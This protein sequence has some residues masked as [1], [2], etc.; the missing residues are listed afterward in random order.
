MERWRNDVQHRLSQREGRERLFESYS[1][2]VCS[3]L[4]SY[5]MDGRAGAPA[6]SNEYFRTEA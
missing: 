1:I 4:R 3:Q 6:D 2:T 5:T